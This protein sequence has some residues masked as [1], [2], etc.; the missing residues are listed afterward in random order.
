[1]SRSTN[2]RA[3]RMDADS[4]GAEQPRVRITKRINPCTCGCLGA[5]SWHKREFVRTVRHITPEAGTASCQDIGRVAF[6][7]SGRARFPFGERDV[8]RVVDVNGYRLGW[9]LAD[10]DSIRADDQP[11]AAAQL[12]EAEEEAEEEEPT[13]A[14]VEELE[15]TVERTYREYEWQQAAAT[16]D[17]A[18]LERAQKAKAAGQPWRDWD[19]T[20]GQHA[21]VCRTLQEWREAQAALDARRAAGPDVA[22]AG[23]CDWCGGDEE[24]GEHTRA[25]CTA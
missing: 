20:L 2:W 19:D 15:A 18:E 3:N 12:L 7:A 13:T 17:A 14:T 23:V 1:M 10:E 5:D 6:D 4:M 8:I 16:Y 9:F 25:R 21:V 22:V 11:Q 24:E